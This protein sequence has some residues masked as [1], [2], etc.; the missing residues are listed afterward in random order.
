MEAMSLSSKLI[1]RFEATTVYSHPKATADIVFVHGLNGAPDRTWTASNGIFWPLQLLVPTLVDAPANIIVYGYN[2]D[3]ATWKK[4]MSPTDN[5]VYHHAQNLVMSLA[6]HR[7]NANTTRNPIIWVCHSLGGVVAKRA[8]LYSNDVRDPELDLWRSIYVSTYAMIFLGTPHT[9]SNLASWGRILQGMSGVVPKKVFDSEPVLLKTL[10]KEN[11]T[12]QE[13]NVHFL[14]IYRRFK[15]HM[16]R[17]NQ[18]TDLKWTVDFVVD[19]NSAGPQLPGV[20]YYSIEATHSTMCKFPTADAPGYSNVSSA[21]LQWVLEAPDSIQTRWRVE[22]E[23]RA[24]RALNDVNEIVKHT[25]VPASLHTPLR[26]L[27]P[28]PQLGAAGDGGISASPP[29]SYASDTLPSRG[30]MESSLAGSQR[31]VSSMPQ[32]EES[33]PKQLQPLVIH[34]HRIR[35]NA[36]FK[37][38]QQE[39]ADLHRNLRDSSR[40][41][42]G[43]SA[44]LL[45]SIPGG[46]K[47]HLARQYVY[48]HGHDYRGGIYWIPSRS[49]QE[50]EEAFWKIAKSKTIREFEA[51]PWKR[52]LLDPRKLVKTVR[53]WFETFDDWLIV[54]DGILFDTPRATSFIPNA[55][56]TSILYTS[57]NR[58]AH[59]DHKFDN[60][61]LLELGRLSQ[62]DAQE[63]LLEEM[64]KKEPFTPNDLTQAGQAVDLMDRLP[65]M[66][67]VA[68]QHLKAT[69]EPLV[70]YIHSFKDRRKAG[71][72]HAYKNVREELERRGAMEALNLMYILSFFAHTIPVEMFVLGIHALDNRTPIRA[73]DAAHR[74]SLNHTLTVLIQWALIGRNENDDGSSTSS[75]SSPPSVG[76]VSDTSD[77]LRLHSIIQEFFIDTMIESKE[78]DFWFERAV[79]VFCHSY[80][81]A[82][83]RI[84][85]DP[86]IGLPDDYRR[87]SIHG[88]HLLQCLERLAKKHPG[89]SQLRSPLLERLGS[90]SLGIEELTKTLSGTIMQGRSDMIPTSIFE[91]TSSFSDSDSTKTSRE[92]MRSFDERR[93]SI[94]HVYYPDIVESP[95]IYHEPDVHLP[96]QIPYP[97]GDQFPIFIP[98]L[99]EDV[100]TDGGVQTPRQHSPK[101]IWGIPPDPSNHRTVKKLEERRYHDRAG[102]MRQVQGDHA[103]ARL[104]VNQKSVAGEISSPTVQL[105]SAS[106]QS[107]DITARSQLL[108]ISSS[109]SWRKKS[110]PSTAATS[111]FWSLLG[112]PFRKSPVISESSSAAKGSGDDATVTQPFV[113]IVS[114]DGT[115][116]DAGDFLVSSPAGGLSPV[117]RQ[118]SNESAAIHERLSRSDVVSGSLSH[119]AWDEEPRR[120]VSVPPR[121]QQGA[122]YISD[123]DLRSFPPDHP[124]RDSFSVDMPAWPESLRPTGY[125]SQ[126]MSR[127]TSD[128]PARRSPDM[129]PRSLPLGSMMPRVRQ[130]RPSNVETEPS[131]RLA[132]LES[133]PFQSWEERHVRGRSRHVT[134]FPA[135]RR[136]RTLGV[137]KS[138]FVSS[139][140]SIGEDA[141]LSGGILTGDGN[142]VAFGREG[143]DGDE[144]GDGTEDGGNGTGYAKER[145][146]KARDE[147]LRGVGLGIMD[148]E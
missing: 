109:L 45:Q 111:P 90:I 68:G 1:K 21:I 8:L 117:T 116:L 128:N 24:T 15:I 137:G 35:P 42:I 47:S 27:A 112:K 142:L 62:Q 50:M 146:G 78:A 54:F 138:D 61:I 114:E 63:L 11:A 34:P 17:E 139:G 29:P 30:D 147:D 14:D 127:Q 10:K 18:K 48:L 144:E 23:E 43:T 12:L 91:L 124:P 9:G 70:K 93:D 92:T 94:S 87:Y 5:F 4:D 145:D 105:D 88:K 133:G 73:K 135:S 107:S 6:T 36:H 39:L 108:K 57:T 103:D 81:S 118:S 66:I 77:T 20:T 75:S 37:G 85:Q 96:Q 143:V 71:G 51:V 101:R 113:P 31:S 55:K 119:P 120:G 69:R 131:P 25:G 99:P 53:K 115:P 110:A 134:S 106:E 76:L 98:R 122:A 22:E 79:A 60:P 121:T 102:S 95:V 64:G 80:D 82:D 130:R 148:G 86:K 41:Q 97:P 46:G 59:G 7:R 38:R 83:L 74:R 89:V 65:L 19:A 16:V 26:L 136:G 58:A 56:N 33:R 72:L 49:E 129:T 100:N 104:N 140:L 13:I 141:P 40:R 2:A 123:E 125:T 132:Q 3:V 32:L 44:V 67:H 84:R 52:D 126:P 28:S